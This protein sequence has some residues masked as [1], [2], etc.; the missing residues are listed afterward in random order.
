MPGRGVR[1]NS[2]CPGTVDSPWLGR[3]LAEAQD[4]DEARRQLVGRQPMGRL[5]TPREVAAAALYLASN[6]AAFITG[7]ELL[8]DGGLVAG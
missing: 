6:D 3:L 7:T 8:I 2:I 1:C 4:P 5:A